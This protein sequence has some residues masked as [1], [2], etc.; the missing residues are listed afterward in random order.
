MHRLPKWFAI[1]TVLLGFARGPTAFAE[2]S[3]AMPACEPMV[4]GFHGARNPAFMQ[5]LLDFIADALWNEKELLVHTRLFSWGDKS[6]S[7]ANAYVARRA[8]N[9]PQRP[10]V[11]FIGHSYG[12]DS[13][14][15]AAARGEVDLLVTLDAVSLLS[16]PKFYPDGRWVNAYTSQPSDMVAL[17][18]VIL[19]ASAAWIL[20]G[21]GACDLVALIG[22]PWGPESRA[23][24]NERVATGHCDVEALY[25]PVHSEV[26][27]VL[28][29]SDADV[30]RRIAEKRR[31]AA[32]IAKQLD[33]GLSLP[34]LNP[35][36]PGIVH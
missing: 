27:K 1:V 6:E 5:R 29:R 7:D 14:L 15:D 21:N 34:W 3:A 33:A 36:E 12:G 2:V 22:G 17:P 8:K 9:C 20:G 32:W 25:K 30:R 24:R 10:P 35:W 13:A 19:P 31:E 16:W 11:V 18:F 23:N 28:T 26:A 4:I